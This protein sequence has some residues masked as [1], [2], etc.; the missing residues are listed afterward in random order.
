MEIG[1]IRVINSSLIDERSSLFLK[2]L[3][4]RNAFP[5]IWYKKCH[6]GYYNSR[7][8]CSFVINI[9]KNLKDASLCNN[10]N[11]FSDNIM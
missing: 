11:V 1:K 5:V 7:S 2:H 3:C 9:Y 10:C 8:Y 6:Q 4:Y